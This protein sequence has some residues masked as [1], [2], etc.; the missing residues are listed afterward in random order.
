MNEHPQ[1]LRFIKL[2]L[3]VCYLIPDNSSDVLNDHSV[4]LNVSSSI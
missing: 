2:L 3:P 4:L 1:Y